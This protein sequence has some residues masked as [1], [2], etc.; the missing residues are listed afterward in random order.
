VAPVVEADLAYTRLVQQGLPCLPVRL[1]LDRPPAGL[2]EDEG[3]VFPEGTGGTALLALG[4]SV[5]PQASTSWIG[6][7]KV[8]RLRSAL[9]SS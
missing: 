7:A 2:S 9:G 8:R 3:V 5:G 4:G 1:P 6:S